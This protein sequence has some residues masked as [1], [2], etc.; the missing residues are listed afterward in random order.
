LPYGCGAVRKNPQEFVENVVKA[1]QQPAKIPL[2]EAVRQNPKGFY[3]IALRL[4]ELLT[5]YLVTTFALNYS[6]K[7]L[8]MSSSLFLNIGLMVGAISCFTIPFFAHIS[9]RFGR[10]RMCVMGGLIGAACAFPFFFALESGSTLW[11]VLFAI[12][13]ANLSHDM[14]V[15]VHQP[16]FTE[17]F[18]TAY[19]Y[20]GA[21][22]GYQVASIVG[23]GF[24]AFYC[25]S[26][27]DTGK[28]TMA[29]CCCLFN[30]R[31]F[32]HDFGCSPNESPRTIRR[33]F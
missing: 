23:G 19:R 3:I 5:M 29:L 6:T 27:G 25:R 11:I 28:W 14:V 32:T 22:V 4:A 31:L 21:G 18:G 12:L 10:R 20:S 30:G 13:L 33:I 15:S 9:D 2:F 8:G 7:N 17:L 1:K 24:H 16:I 26:T